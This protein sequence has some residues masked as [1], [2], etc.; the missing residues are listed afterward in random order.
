VPSGRRLWF[1]GL[2]LAISGLAGLSI[3]MNL[4]PANIASIMGSIWPVPLI[5][6]LLILLVPIFRR[7]T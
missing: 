1:L 6:L 2:L 3:T 7:K 5:L 4:I